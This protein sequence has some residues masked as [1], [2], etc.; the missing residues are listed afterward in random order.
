MASNAIGL[1]L[2]N[3]ERFVAFVVD[4]VLRVHVVVLVKHNNVFGNAAG[5][6]IHPTFQRT[7]GVV[8]V[9]M[10][11]V[12]AVRQARIRRAAGGRIQL[13][14][15]QVLR[16]PTLLRPTAVG[17]AIEDARGAARRRE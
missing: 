12:V 8:V 11:R 1:V 10:M 14:L 15:G 17:F 3:L 13:K 16:I 4:N 6:G 7:Q 9:Q 2:N 5:T